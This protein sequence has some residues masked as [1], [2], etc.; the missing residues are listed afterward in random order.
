MKSSATVFM[1]IWGFFIQGDWGPLTFW[2]AENGGLVAFLKA[3]PRCPPTENQ[4]T[5]RWRFQKIAFFWSTLPQTTRD[6]FEKLS[7]RACLRIT[8]YNLFT[9]YQMRSDPAVVRTLQRQT[10]IAFAIP[11]LLDLRH[12]PTT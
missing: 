8:G 6:L 4:I 3:P 2:T 5:N 7:R 11:A 1:R 12:E 10:G 9:Y